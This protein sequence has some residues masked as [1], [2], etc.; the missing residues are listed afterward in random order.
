MPYFGIAD[1]ISGGKYAC[2]ICYC[3]ADRTDDFCVR[4]LE[5]IDESRKLCPFTLFYCDLGK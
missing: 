1:S 5:K 3:G 4:V 2:V